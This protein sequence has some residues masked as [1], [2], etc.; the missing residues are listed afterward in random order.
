M[1]YSG[2]IWSLSILFISGMVFKIISYVKFGF[3]PLSEWLI[4]AIFIVPV[5]WVGLQVDKSR[6]YAKELKEKEQELNQLFNSVDAVI[7]SYDLRSNQLIVS[8]KVKELYGFSS[9][10]FEHNFQLWK[11]VVYHEDL[12]QVLEFEQAL[13]A[14]NGGMSEYRILLPNGEVKWI[15]KRITPIF[16]S[17]RKLI[18]L[19]GID[20]DINERKKIGELLHHTQEQNRKLLVKRLEETEQRYKSLFEHNSEA[21]FTFCL[22]RHLIDANKAAENLLGYS[23][24]EL[25]HMNWESIIVPEDFDKYTGHF[26]SV[27]RYET[28]EMTLSLINKDGSKRIVQMKMIPIITDNEFNGIF[29]IVKDVTESKLA[30]EM[31]RRS[32]KLSAVGQLAAGVAHEI[33]NPLTTLRGFIQF[34]KQDIDKNY[35][36]IMLTELDRINMIVS[37]FLILSKPQGINYQ[38]I[39]L[40]RIVQTIVSLLDTQAKINNVQ[41]LSDLDVDH[42]L[43]TGEPNQLK[44]V[45]INLLKNS[46]EAMPKGG[47][48]TVYL[49]QTDPNALSIV[50][51][52]Q[53]IGIP[54]DLIPKLGEPFFTT[55]EEG[56]G[57]G[58]MV[59]YKIIENHGGAI[60]ISSEPNKGTSVEVSLPINFR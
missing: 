15:Q 43:I 49:K 56:T 22:G 44:Q 2:R 32:D 30:E 14:G 38:L 20:I 3:I 53:G 19:N 17:K 40:K 11:E 59:C 10:E 26:N 27:N 4:N 25:K 16:D 55:K 5:W 35:I 7:F 52:D 6:Y 24:E 36:E 33:R 31:I 54:A 37:E 51:Q 9:N 57:L 23:L 18:K 48:I 8:S 58:L 50:I 13:L 21:I 41:I 45:I 12:E 42:S 46:I 29:E 1:K 34:L 39:D 28:R 60:N 47:E